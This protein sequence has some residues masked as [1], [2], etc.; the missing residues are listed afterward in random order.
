MLQAQT[1]IRIHMSE[2]NM[3]LK[4]QEHHASWNLALHK[5]ACNTAS[6]NEIPFQMQLNEVCD[7]CNA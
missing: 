6:V 1:L 4:L 2:G 7:M 3:L 5:H